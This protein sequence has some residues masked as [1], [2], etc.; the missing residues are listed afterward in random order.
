MLDNL[1]VRIDLYNLLLLVFIVASFSFLLFSVLCGDCSTG[2]LG[3]KSECLDFAAD[4]LSSKANFLRNP[5]KDERLGLLSKVLRVQS[6]S[7]RCNLLP[8]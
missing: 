3:Q 7:L 4:F 2:S 1:S 8:H 6:M 5:P